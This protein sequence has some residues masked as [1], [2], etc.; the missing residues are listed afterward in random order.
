MEVSDQPN[1][2]AALPPREGAP[3]HIEEEDGWSPESFWTLWNREGFRAPARVRTRIIQ[4]VAL[5][6]NYAISP[7]LLEIQELMS[8]VD[9]NYVA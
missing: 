6:I 3:R 7:P 4:P 9:F 1:G 8:G 2:P 5:C